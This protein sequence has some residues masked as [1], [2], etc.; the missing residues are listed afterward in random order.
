LRS[1]ASFDDRALPSEL[2]LSVGAATIEFI[3]G[4]HYNI[5][6]PAEWATL[7]PPNQGRVTLGEQEFDVAMYTDLQCLDTIRAAYVQMRDGSS[8]RSEAA[9]ACLGHLRQAILCTAD[10][11]WS[12]R[13]SSARTESVRCWARWRPANIWITSVAIG[14]RCESLWNRIRRSR[15]IVGN[16]CTLHMRHNRVQNLH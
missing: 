13:G 15:Y 11:R 8:V 7:I 4:K 12:P 16:G 6:N 3:F 2:P 14:C 5:A 10:I 1:T 9:E